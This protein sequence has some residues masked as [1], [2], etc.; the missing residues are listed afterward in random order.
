M[1]LVMAKNSGL[2]RIHHPASV[3]VGA[4]RVRDQRQQHLC[5]P[6]APR[7]RVDTSDHA[8]PE[9]VVPLPCHAYDNSACSQAEG[10][11]DRSARAGHRHLLQGVAVIRSRGD[12][13]RLLHRRR[14]HDASAVRTAGQRH[15]HRGG[16][17]HDRA[18]TGSGSVSRILAPGNSS[19]WARA[20]ASRRSMRSDTPAAS[21]SVAAGSPCCMSISA[22]APRCA[23]ACSRR[24]RSSLRSPAAR[25]SPGC[26]PTSAPRRK[27]R[28]S[29]TEITLRVR[30]VG[31][32]RENTR[33]RQRGLGL[34]R[35][36]VRRDDPEEALGRTLG[37]TWSG[38]RHRQARSG[39]AAAP[40]VLPT[41]IRAGQVPCGWSP[42]RC[43][44]SPVRRRGR[45]SAGARKY[46]SDHRMLDVHILGH[47]TGAP[48]RSRPGCAH[49][50]RSARAAF[51]SIALRLGDVGEQQLGACRTGHGHRESD[52][53]AAL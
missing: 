8:A 25:S 16:K 52:G 49:R 12:G 39:E 44:R 47:A 6:A 48:R 53:V 35:A 7:C 24:S 26:P 13:R 31:S 32:P 33:G 4:A 20:L 43:R 10:V 28:G 19:G 22:D 41:M 42:P 11:Q 46:R 51:R 3:H 36:V 50:G 45:R 38:D 2:G 18:V 5:D 27:G 14:A 30:S 23:S 1:R 40:P 9:H 17:H 29:A 37:E 21:R 15:R 34:G